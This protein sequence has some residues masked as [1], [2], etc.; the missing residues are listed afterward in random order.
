MDSI[1]NQQRSHDQEEK[2]LL[3]RIEE[4]RKMIVD[5]N[6]ENRVF[7]QE[8][9]NSDPSFILLSLRDSRDAIQESTKLLSKFA[10][11]IIAVGNKLDCSEITTDELLA[12]VDLRIKKNKF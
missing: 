5:M 1:V 8:V 3:Q 9:P 2:S 12:E 6:A 10:A 11:L 4:S 7:D